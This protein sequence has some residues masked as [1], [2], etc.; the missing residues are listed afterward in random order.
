MINLIENVTKSGIEAVIN[1]KP[2]K[3][4][5]GNETNL[6]D[7]YLAITFRTPEGYTA[8]GAYCDSYGEQKHV[9]ALSTQVG[10]PMRCHFCEV[11]DLPYC[12]SLDA[13]EL[14]D[15]AVI[16]AQRAYANGFPLDDKPIKV[17]FVEMGEPF[18]NKGLFNGIEKITRLFPAT[19][20]VSTTF[21][22][23]SISYENAER[24]I[25][26]S[27]IYNHPVQMQLSLHS[28]DEDYRMS[29][30]KFPLAGFSEIAKFGEKWRKYA[31]SPRKINLSLTLNRKTPCSPSG[32]ANILDPEH[33][34]VRL[35]NMLPTEPSRRN[36]LDEISIEEILGLE[37]EFR[38]CGYD[39]IP[40]LSADVETK[41]NL[42]PG[43]LSKLE[44]RGQQ[45]AMPDNY[46]NG[47][48]R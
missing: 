29:V 33:F 47:G 17:A 22:D 25:H 26:L 8:E 7:N 20:K 42:N 21:P 9:L 5:L 24:M 6:V 31:K 1:R 18:M 40:G 12:R 16:I 48:L 23:H 4:R 19:V 14:E 32:I 45:I 39:I 2:S 3:L 36:S 13:Q 34:A 30:C 27:S 41:F 44:E 46:T 28:T 15:E 37:D 43:M 10:C 38:R 35:R 11:A